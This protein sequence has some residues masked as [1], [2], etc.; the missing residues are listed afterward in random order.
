[1]KK[2]PLT[3]G[4]S[5]LVGDDD[6]D[7]IAAVK[8]YASVHPRGVYVQRDTHENGKRVSLLMHRV[9]MSA[10]PGTHVDHINGDC[11]DNRKSNLR[12]CSRSEN[13]RNRRRVSGRSQYKG[14]V[15]VPHLDKWQAQII[16]DKRTIN[17]GVHRNE[18]DAALAYDAAA[19]TYHR[20]FACTNADLGLL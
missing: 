14:V 2:I 7:R 1:M 17:L 10:P 3:K 13:M 6:C 19:P 16:V 8:W 11:L 9:I 4:Y 20:E 12:V 15:Y 5:A 18:R